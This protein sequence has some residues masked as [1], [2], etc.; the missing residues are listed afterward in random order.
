MGKRHV[1]VF[2]YM[3]A[4]F[5]DATPNY[6]HLDIPLDGGGIRRTWTIDARFHL[7]IASKAIGP[8][9]GTSAIRKASFARF[10]RATRNEAIGGK[11]LCRLLPPLRLLLAS[12]LIALGSPREVVMF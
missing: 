9:S 10:P 3:Y 8:A 11:L 6:T 5:S 7:R 4:R 1:L 12:A 2:A